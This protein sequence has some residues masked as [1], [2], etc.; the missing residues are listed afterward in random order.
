MG[1]PTPKTAGLIG[2]GL[3]GRGWMILFAVAGWNVRVFDANLD[4]EAPA[5]ASV[6]GNLAIMQEEG[7]IA[8]AAEVEARIRFVPTLEAAVEGVDWVQESVFEDVEVKRQV[9]DAASALTEPEVVI[10][11]SGGGIPP[12]DFT[13]TASHR[14]RCLIVHPFN[15]PH[16]VPVVELVRATWTSDQAIERAKAVMVELGR[17]PVVVNRAIMGFVLNRLQGVVIDEAIALVG[18][19]IISPED[20]DACMSHGLGRRWTFMGP[21]ETME[22]NSVGGF[23]EY[24][25][26]YGPLYRQMMQVERPWTEATLDKI[27]AWR[28]AEYPEIDD[29]TARRLWR[30]RTLIKLGKAIGATS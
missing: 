29:I 26:R 3:I 15:P 24:A 19:G 23:K 9:Y 8:S 17:K 13:A 12:D 14:E 18:D 20:L 27:E 11:S 22:M 4:G 7:L 21:F 1:E 16:L 5:R 25:T 28:R 6:R 30:D 10:G 2:G